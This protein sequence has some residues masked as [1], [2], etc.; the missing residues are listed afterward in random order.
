MS[1]VDQIF[2]AGVIGCGGAG[3]PTHVKYG[4]KI[5]HLIINGAECEPLLRTDRYIMRTFADR[6]V[7]A[8]VLL[9]K[10]LKIKHVTFA[11]KEGYTR[12]ITALNAAIKSSRSAIN[13]HLM[14]SFY[15][16]G[17]EQTMVYE[18]TGKV[19]P[20]AGIPMD[21]G[22]V[23]TNVAT[24]LAISD[25]AHG[26][27]F[28]RK[29]LTVTGEVANPS[30]LCVPVGTPLK[31]CIEQAGGA[32]IKEWSVLL[33]GPMMGKIVS[34]KEA[35]TLFV[36]KTTSGIV[37]LPKENLLERKQITAV[38][39]M[40]NRARMSCIRCSQC[41]E[42]CPRH[43]LGHPIE[44]HKIMRS[45]ALTG[46]LGKLSVDD[47]V[48]KMSLIC[49]QCGVCELV[50][51]PMELQPRS[52]FREA[53]KIAGAA[54]I[55]YTKGEGQREVH[56]VRSW[57]QPST[58]RVAARAGVEKYQNY[59]IENFVELQAGQVK[60]ALNMQIGAPC[61]PVVQTGD[62]VE[63]GQLIARCPEG[64]LGANLHAS[65]GGT[66]TCMDG[67]ILITEYSKQGSSDES[68]VISVDD[69]REA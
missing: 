52:L 57:R 40:A 50:A 22:C 8:L 27:P 3:F 38:E 5:E 55:R 37:L 4:G 15:P 9:K 2:E 31:T 33:G 1:I 7:Q 69:G 10:E 62:I 48:I 63:A 29:Y 6:L 60:L 17:D 67:A 12:E 42:L 47:P 35:E 58:K 46:S 34:A 59:R 11:L 68:N 21:V 49:C 53:K 24:L 26:I 13:V 66:V 45:L 65:I 44:P 14:K 43:L 32:L 61:I 41:T 56:P 18:V 64:K 51:C 19:V 20:P 28:T 39:R 25:A 16:A 30:V 54:G 36:T 23:I